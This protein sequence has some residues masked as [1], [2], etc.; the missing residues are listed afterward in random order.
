MAFVDSQ[1][2]QQIRDFNERG[3]VGPDPL[4]AR[5][6]DRR[7]GY[8][9]FARPLSEADIEALRPYLF[10]YAEKR[11]PVRP[12]D[13]Q[14]VAV[15]NFIAGEWRPPGSGEHATMTSPAD[16]RVQLFDVPASGKQDVEAALSAGFGAW[17]SLAWAEEGLAY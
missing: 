12:S 11:I 13:R 4:A 7:A 1:L 15:R 17:K 10:C 6:A 8:S 3:Q 2:A 14:R 16:R 9:L 5:Y